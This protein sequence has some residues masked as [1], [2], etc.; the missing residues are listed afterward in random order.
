[1]TTKTLLTNAGRVAF[2]LLCAAII[3]SAL[4]R[5]EWAAR[6]WDSTYD[7]YWHLLWSERALLD[8]NFEREYSNFI[9]TTPVSM[10]NA[11]A[12][13]LT[14]L[15]GSTEEASLTWAARTPTIVAYALLLAM[16]FVIGRA[17][18]DARAGLLATTLTALD[19]NLTTHASLATVDIYFALVTLC[20]LYQSIRFHTQ[21]SLREAG[22]LGAV[23]GVGLVVKLSTV[24]FF[25]VLG[26]IL[27]SVAA[28]RGAEHFILTFLQYALL[29]VAVASFIVSAAYKFHEVGFFLKDLTLYSGF[30]TALQREWP[31][32][33]FLLPASFLESFDQTLSFE[34]NMQWN[35]VIFDQYISDGAWYYFPVTWFLKTPVGLLLLVLVAG[36]AAAQQWL[37]RRRQAARSPQ[38]P[39]PDNVA[40]RGVLWIVLLQWLIFFLYFNFVFRTHVGLRYILMGLPMLY[41]LCVFALQGTARRRWQAVL[42]PLCLV[43]ALLEQWPYRGNILSFSNALVADKD[44]A[45]YVLTDSNIDWGQNYSGV[46]RQAASEY[47]D[48]ILNPPH[49]MPGQNL[50][51]LNYLTGVFRNFPQYRWVREN[52]EPVRHLQHTHLLYEVSDA[53]YAEFLNQENRARSVENLEDCRGNIATELPYQWVA[54]VQGEHP[55]CLASGAGLVQVKVLRGWGLVGHLENGYCEGYPMSTE[56]QAYFQTDQTPGQLCL[57]SNEAGTLWEV[58]RHTLGLSSTEP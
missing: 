9:A 57:A 20:F 5:V 3:A 14:R 50:I 35:T 45:W 17:M 53:R 48:A 1:M 29:G 34:R 18:L 8:T 26:L 39:A 6:H 55:L 44:N 2:A 41:L 36:L 37:L 40:V 10:F 43:V 25:P 22:L 15:A 27:L 56:D 47:P 42:I 31:Y 49:I 21:P 28:R 7:E 12:R 24:L 46:L 52:L 33:Y 32:L 30:M 51:R 13:H 4:L 58:T 23:I 11:G 54:E 19:P 38:T 16:V